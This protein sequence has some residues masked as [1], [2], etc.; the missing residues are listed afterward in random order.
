[1]LVDPL[2]PRVEV[3]GAALVSDRVERPVGVSSSDVIGT[4]TREPRP[5]PATRSVSSGG[6]RLDRRAR[7]RSREGQT[8]SR[9]RR[10]SSG[11]FTS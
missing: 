1:M 11:P 6:S 9:V 10:S 5:C 8:R 4:V 3:V 7:S 2:A